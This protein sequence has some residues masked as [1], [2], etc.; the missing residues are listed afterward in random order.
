MVDGGRKARVVGQVLHQGHR[1]RAVRG[2]RV[3]GRA[4]SDPVQGNEGD[5]A[6]LLGRQVLDA[7]GSDLVV[8]HDDVEG[9]L[10][11]LRAPEAGVAASAAAV[12]GGFIL[13]SLPEG[14]VFFSPPPER[15]Q[16]D[17][18]AFQVEVGDPGTADLGCGHV[19]IDGV[20]PLGAVEAKAGDGA[21]ALDQKG[22]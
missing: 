16:D 8:R 2:G 19:G 14:R 13:L 3:G 7:G 6:R 18:V 12:G 10:G 20:Q 1:V 21:G 15:H 17:V 22:G 4:R 11:G 5:A 9:R